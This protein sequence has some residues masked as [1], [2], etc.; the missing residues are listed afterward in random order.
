[1][2]FFCKDWLLFK[3]AKFKLVANFLSV[4]YDPFHW[5][6]IGGVIWLIP[7][8]WVVGFI[9]AD[10]F[11]APRDSCPEMAADI[12]AIEGLAFGIGV[13]TSWDLIN[14]GSLLGLFIV[15][16]FENAERNES[17]ILIDF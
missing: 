15:I 1:V 9:V 2:I 11:V 5:L 13:G 8:A 14:N 16:V 4:A 12:F 7:V 3:L 10:G 6:N 17:N